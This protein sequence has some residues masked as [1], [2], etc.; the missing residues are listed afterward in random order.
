MK[1]L[2][3]ATLGSALL[4]LSACQQQEESRERVQLLEASMDLTEI[5]VSQA[6]QVAY[7][8]VVNVDFLKVSN[9]SSK[10]EQSIPIEKV[11]RYLFTSALHSCIDLIVF[12]RCK[13]EHAQ[14]FPLV[15]NILQ[16]VH[17]IR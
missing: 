1:T 5:I 16:R 6:N 11:E 14:V 4:A 3:W 10:S 17:R 9:L 13:N 12:V 2:G 8:I 7:P 15:H